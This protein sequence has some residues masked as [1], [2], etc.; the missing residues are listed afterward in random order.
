MSQQSL[1]YKQAG[2]D[3]EAGDSL[4]DAILPAAKKTMRPEVMAHLGGYAGLFK[5]D[6][7]KY[8][9]PV[10]VSSTDGIGTKLKLAIDLKKF[11]TLGYDLVGMCVNDILC[12][13]AEPVIF[14]DYFA[15]GRL[16]VGV[17]RTVIE[18]VA[19]ALKEINC[20]LIGGETAEMPG[21]YNKGDFDLAGFSVGLVEKNKIVDGSR[22]QVGDVLLGLASSG[23]H[24]NGYSLIRKIIEL[25]KLDLNSPFENNKILGEVLLAPTTLYVNSVLALQKEV[26]VLGIAHITG[27]GIVENLPRIL[28]QGV[29]AKIEKNKI[30]TPTIFNYLQTKGNVPTEEMWRVFNMGIGLIL[31]VRPDQVEKSCSLLKQAGQPATVIGTVQTRKNNLEVEL[32]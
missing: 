23:P 11:D 10:M 31:V 8:K 13:G 28:P 18:S 30:N 14:L 15:T 3:M 9:E 12:C 6:L 16:E 19:K 4:V 29:S 32:V 7:T 5:I 1:T 2:V 24:S 21:L 17:A 22:I 25:A 20:A 26:D 27:G